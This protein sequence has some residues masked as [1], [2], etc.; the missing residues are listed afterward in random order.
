MRTIPAASCAWRSA[1][2]AA[3]LL[4]GTACTT[5]PMIRSEPVRASQTDPVAG[6]GYYLPKTVVRVD[7]YVETTTRRRPVLGPDRKARWDGPPDLDGKGKPIGDGGPTQ[8]IETTRETA[9]FGVFAGE[10]LVP[11]LRHH[12]VIDPK[13]DVRS[14]DQ[15]NVEVSPEGML[16]RVC[17]EAKDETHDIATNLAGLVSLLVQAPAR[18]GAPTRGVDLNAADLP[19]RLVSSLEFDPTDPADFARVQ[20]YLAD[21]AVALDIHRQSDCPVA[22]SGSGCCTTCTTGQPGVYY[23]LPVPYRMQLNPGGTS[24]TVAFVGATQE[25][26]VAAEGLEGPVDRTFL[27]PNEAICKYVPVTRASFVTKKTSLEFDHGM[28]T[29]ATTNKPSELLAFVKIPVDVATTILGIPSELLKIRIEQNNRQQELI[30]SRTSVAN[31]EVEQLKAMT[32]LLNAT[33]AA[34]AAQADK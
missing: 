34:N 25:T 21:H 28:L 8:R 5:G 7:L 18:L 1:A 19:V 26:R 6:I 11:D 20:R 30:Q 9:Y 22:T 24:R 27:L 2:K 14:S 23:R 15:L 4:V 16:E 17:G 33:S 29:R 12:F 31:S 3:L 13:F 10:R 32:E